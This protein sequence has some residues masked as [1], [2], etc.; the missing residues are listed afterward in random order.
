MSKLTENQKLGFINMLM[1]FADLNEPEIL[2]KMEALGE[3]A[4]SRI[5]TAGLDKNFVIAHMLTEAEKGL[6]SATG[7]LG[8]I[9]DDC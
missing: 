3:R 2:D 4:S 6:H 5:E 9:L 8:K 7:T 1:S